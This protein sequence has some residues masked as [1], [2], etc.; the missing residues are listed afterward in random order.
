MWV[1]VSV[2]RK[3]KMEKMENE[4]MVSCWRYGLSGLGGRKKKKK[5]SPKVGEE[6]EKVLVCG[7]KW[8]K[9]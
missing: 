3:K 5:K 8:E 1:S 7:G 4:E 2:E 9:G 6:M